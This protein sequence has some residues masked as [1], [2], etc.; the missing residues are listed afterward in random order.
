M[1]YFENEVP[2]STE[3]LLVLL[4]QEPTLDIEQELQR[5]LLRCVLAQADPANELLFNRHCSDDQQL[6]CL[7]ENAEQ[8]R[9]IA[10]GLQKA[11][12]LGGGGDA[13]D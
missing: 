7:I 10:Q 5:R 4:Q 6:G 11:W 1:L 8:V 2:D 3:R 13:H 12:T 9:R